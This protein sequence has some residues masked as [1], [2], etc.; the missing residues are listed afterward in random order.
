MINKYKKNQ[1][2]SGRLFRTQTLL[3]FL[4]QAR[5][6]QTGSGENSCTICNT[7]VPFRLLALAVVDV[8]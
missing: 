2:I 6:L 3:L 1:L 4:I 7:P 5:V 8:E